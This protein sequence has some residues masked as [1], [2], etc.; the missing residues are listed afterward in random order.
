MSVL[1]IANNFLSEMT[2]NGKTLKYLFSNYEESEIYWV[3]TR[4]LSSDL[5]CNVERSYISPLG[6]VLSGYNL[7][8]DKACPKNVK[9]SESIWANKKAA[10]LRKNFCLKLKKIS[11]SALPV[12]GFLKIFRE[13]PLFLRYNSILSSILKDCEESGF[14]DFD[15]IVFVAGD[16]A[17][18]H[19]LFLGVSNAYSAK[20]CVFITDDYCLEYS[21]IARYKFRS[22]L[23]SMVLRKWFYTTLNNAD[24][25]HF[26]SEKMKQTYKEVFPV[27]GCRL[28]FNASEMRNSKQTPQE[29]ILDKKEFVLSYFGSLHSGRYEALCGFAKEVESFNKKNRLRFVIHA[30]SSGAAQYSNGKCVQPKSLRLLNALSGNDFNEA[31]F[32]SDALLIIESYNIRDLRRTWLSFSTKA[33]E[34]LSSGKP[35]IAVGPMGNPSI[36]VLVSS[37]AALHVESEDDLYKIFDKTVIES[38]NLKAKD[39]YQDLR[40]KNAFF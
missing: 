12:R 37:G 24:N 27:T 32:D 36:E 2:N 8:E 15:K 22:G 21:S 19:N 31:F 20:K 34:Y 1:V 38:I 16:F 35:I 6:G 39:A 25:T 7:T 11:S 40:L 26:I 5:V 13:I 18:L 28:S 4:P 30:Y 23:H 3:Y 9:L 14:N 29:K 17:F 10:R 33:M